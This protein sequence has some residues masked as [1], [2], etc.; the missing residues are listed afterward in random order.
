MLTIYIGV[1]YIGVNEVNQG[2]EMHTIPFTEFPEIIYI[3]ETG[4]S[5]NGTPQFAKSV[6]AENGRYARFAKQSV[7]TSDNR[8]LEY[9][10]SYWAELVSEAEGIRCYRLACTAQAPSGKLAVSVA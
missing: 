10:W 2:F 5:V 1:R 6:K 8:C 3:N 9:A 4:R 7:V